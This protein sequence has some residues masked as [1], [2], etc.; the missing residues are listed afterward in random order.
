MASSPIA[1]ARARETRARATST[2]TDETRA[3]APCARRPPSWRPSSAAVS[4]IPV[5]GSFSRRASQGR[6]RRRS[7]DFRLQGGSRQAAIAR[8]EA[9]VAA[10]R[11]RGGRL[12]K[13][14]RP[15]ALPPVGSPTAA[16]PKAGSAPSRDG[17]DSG[18]RYGGYGK[19]RRGDD[20]RRGRDAR[21]CARE[22]EMRTSS[23]GE[24]RCSR[25]NTWAAVTRG[26]RRNRRI[27][28]SLCS[29]GTRRRTRR[30]I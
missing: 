5:V 17:R 25:D 10:Q 2:P 3:C 19:K 30:V 29:I 14:P 22:D 23:R 1:G 26:K 21:G 8:R 24:L 27:G 6:Q 9:E 11:A 20:R 13:R 28:A 15:A 4:R 16:A 12:E 18:G 7:T